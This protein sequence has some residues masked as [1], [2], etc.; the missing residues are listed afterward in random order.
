MAVTALALSAPAAALASSLVFTDTEGPGL[1]KCLSAAAPTACAGA[2]D[3]SSSSYSFTLDVGQTFDPISLITEAHLTI[4]L[5]DDGGSADGSEKLDITVDGVLIHNNA[6]ANHGV[7]IDFSSFGSLGDGKVDVILTARRG[8][9]FYEGA[10]LTV[11][12]DP[13]TAPAATTPDAAVPAPAAL[14]LLSSGLA[15]VAWSRRRRS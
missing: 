8:D 10:T 7:T 9:F 2:G 4:D 13:P 1:H 14:V 15:G 12:D 3:P 5:A 6:D 11:W